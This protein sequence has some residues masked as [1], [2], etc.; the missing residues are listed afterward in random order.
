MII[1]L[2]YPTP[3]EKTAAYFVG[4]WYLT[5]DLALMDEAGYLG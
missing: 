1:P 2:L 5:G 4:D 3:P